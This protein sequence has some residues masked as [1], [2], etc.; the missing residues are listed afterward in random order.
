[1]FKFNSLKHIKWLSL[2]CLLSQP[3]ELSAFRS[4]TFKSY[5]DP[6]YQSFRPKHV[7]VRADNM[8]SEMQQTIVA[9]DVTTKTGDTW[10][11]NQKNDAI[12]TAIKAL[13]KDNIIN[14]NRR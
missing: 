6:D 5:T 12:K 9:A 2:L 8:S 4:S 10:S 1:M 7:L 3:F 11:V 14:N 13:K